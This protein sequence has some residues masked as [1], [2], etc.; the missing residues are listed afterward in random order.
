MFIKGKIK[1]TGTQ[2]NAIDKK[3]GNICMCYICFHDKIYYVT[4]HVK[5]R[6]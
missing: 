4:V 6:V 1:G 2:E 5:L 3:K